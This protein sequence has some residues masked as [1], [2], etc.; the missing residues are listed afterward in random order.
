MRC[1]RPGNA[2]QA[3]L[4]GLVVDAERRTR[5]KRRDR[6]LHVV[7]A[8]QRAD[9]GQV[10]DVFGFAGAGA[11][12]VALAA[13]IAM[14]DD[15]VDRHR[16]DLALHGGEIFRHA[17]SVIVV[18]ADDAHLRAAENAAL[19]RGVML[20]GAVPVDMIGRDVEHDADG[21]ID[22]G[23]KIDLV[24]RAFDHVMPRRGQRIELQHR[25]ADI[26]AHLHVAAGVAEQM[27]DQRGGGGFA[28]GAGDGDERRV[29]RLHAALAAEQFDIADDLDAG[30]RARASPP[31]AAPDASAARRAS[32]S[33][34]ATVDQSM[35]RKSAT[36]AP[37]S[38]ACATFFGSSSNAMTSARPAI[39]A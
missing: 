16:H 30:S 17:A 31:N 24:G 39:S 37:A 35:P 33:S 4:Q 36:R 34:A 14:R 22:R 38:A 19:H 5:R 29:G 28:V 26:A 32:G 6:V 21:R 9:A 2:A 18:D 20:D 15:P 25:H 23:R 12:D 7:A 10:G 3:V 27:R 11:I 13:D 8:A 1:A